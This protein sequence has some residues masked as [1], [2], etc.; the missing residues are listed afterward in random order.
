MIK[1]MIMIDDYNDDYN[2]DDKMSCSDVYDWID[3]DYD[4]LNDD[5]D[6]ADYD[7]NDYD[8]DDDQ[9]YNVTIAMI[10]NVTII[11]CSTNNI[12]QWLSLNCD[13]SYTNVKDWN[14]DS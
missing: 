10:F 14:P 6:Y 7:Y 4:L 11:S 5:N 2:Y 13:T 12:V 1:T 3:D 8:D 9:V